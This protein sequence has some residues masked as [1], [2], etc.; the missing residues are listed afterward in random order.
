MPYEVI[1]RS[2]DTHTCELPDP[3]DF[4]LGTEIRC[5]E[6]VERMKGWNPPCGNRWE[7]RVT[8]FR[9]RPIW[10]EIVYSW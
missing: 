1:K 4:E 9:R 10:K 5:T 7:R 8:F 6:T 3:A 2:Y